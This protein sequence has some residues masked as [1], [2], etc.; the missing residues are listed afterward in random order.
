MGGSTLQ[1]RSGE[2]FIGFTG[3]SHENA[4][5]FE[6]GQWSSVKSATGFAELGKGIYLTDSLELCVDILAVFNRLFYTDDLGL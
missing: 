3:T 5:K 4:E 1:G 6:A 2:E